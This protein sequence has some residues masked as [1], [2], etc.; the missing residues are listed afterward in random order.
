VRE[1]AAIIRA[2]V[3]PRKLGWVTTNDMGVIISGPQDA[4]RGVDVGF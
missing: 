1:I 4:M 3:I 2:H